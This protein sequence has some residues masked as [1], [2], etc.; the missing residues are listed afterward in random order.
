VTGDP[1]CAHCHLPVPRGRRRST[2]GAAQFCC[3]GC[4]I[5]S[6]LARP[7]ASELES[8]P[9]NTLLLRLG[10]GI[11]LSMNI[12]VFNWLFY[13]RE[14]FGPAAEASG[15]YSALAS[16]FAYLLMFL[17]TVVLV[18]LGAPLAADALGGL[19]AGGSAVPG[20]SRWVGF[21]I[22]ANLLICIGVASAYVVSVAHTLRGSGSLY[23]DTAAMVLLLV[24]LGN[25]LEAGAKRSAANEAGALLASV[26]ERVWVRRD[27]RSLELDIGK[28]VVGDR[29]RVRAGEAVA[30]DGR[31][32]E[33]LSHVD[34]SSLTGESQPRPVKPGDRLY[35][36]SLNLEGRLWLE[37]RRTGG[38]SAVRRM[39]RMLETARLQQPPIQRVADRIAARFVPAV[40][41][42]AAGAFAWHG[43][44]EGFTHGL[45]VALSVLLISCPCALG[46][47]APM[48]TWSALRRAAGRGIL[49]D[50]ATTLERAA[51]VGQVFFD[52]TGTLTE[53]RLELRNIAVGPGLEPDEVLRWAA[54][55]ESASLHPIAHALVG[56]ADRRGLNRSDVERARVLPGLGVEATL[57]GRRLRLGSERLAMRYGLQSSL[58]ELR[59]TGAPELARDGSADVLVYLLDDTRILAE[60]RL[61]ETLRSGAAEAVSALKR[62]GAEVT[63]LTGDRPGPAR[64]LSEE[65]GIPVESEQLPE[66]KLELL[67]QSR[68]GSNRRNP[69]IAMVGDGIN[70][71]PVLAAA[72]VGFAMGSAADLTKQAGNVRLISD[73]LDRVPLTLGIA[74][75]C[76]RRVRLNLTWAFG[77]NA[78]GLT[79]AAVGLLNPI[80]A[81]S[82]M[83]VSS[84][85]IV[86]VSRRS[87]R[88]DPSRLGLESLPL[89]PTASSATE[90]RSSREARA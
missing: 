68:D 13:S 23:F 65:L 45:F 61:G 75:D 43:R 90:S 55:V 57:D 70:D 54:A 19:T 35:A 72:D 59:S 27:G 56:E 77:Y 53:P 5:A 31:I 86:M 33:G 9:G 78:V 40:I 14:W 87:G 25:Y 24:T 76:M 85:I 39:E 41:L 22:D 46:L 83:I 34:E 79:L 88:I 8:A 10:I 11:F 26:P 58:D 12:M 80:F 51:R 49:I 44:H 84:L 32:V 37:T 73:R 17:A 82:A 16:L 69:A 50:S 1:T 42:L 29:V 4:R 81:A 47:A 63:V 18:L 52:K 21:R 7:A 62:L 28:V 67:R 6:E 74:R 36:G 20:R 60:F 64:R 15:E 2:P 71:A 3:F 38:D 48:A 66:D 30:V 89:T